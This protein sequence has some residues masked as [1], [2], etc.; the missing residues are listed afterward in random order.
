MYCL[1]LS[2][3][4][5]CSCKMGTQTLEHVLQLYPLHRHG[6]SCGLR[7]TLE[8]RLWSTRENVEKT[9]LFI[10]NKSPLQHKRKALSL[11]GPIQVKK[12]RKE[13]VTCK[14]VKSFTR[15]CLQYWR[16]G[17]NNN[18][19]HF[20]HVMHMFVDG[21]RVGRAHSGHPVSKHHWLGW[22]CGLHENQ[23]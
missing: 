17:S 21:V 6:Q 19:T 10:T 20:Y 16:F 14:L 11:H 5:N 8:K 4:K 2:H 7:Q 1:G 23:V 13:R 22:S 18:D 9:V 12:R 15:Q 3:T